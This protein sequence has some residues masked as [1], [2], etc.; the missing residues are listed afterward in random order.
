MQVKKI[1]HFA[2]LVG[3]IGE[4]VLDEL[5]LLLSFTIKCLHF[6]TEDKVRANLQ[7]KEVNVILYVDSL[8][9]VD[10]FAELVEVQLFNCRV[11]VF[12]ELAQEDL[13]Q[14]AGVLVLEMVYEAYE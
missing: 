2:I 9:G 3:K 14:R 5:R 7:N 13:V 6:I 4:G 8:V 12:R 11:W 1:Q 10:V